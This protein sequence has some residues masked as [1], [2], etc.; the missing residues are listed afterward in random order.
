MD[1]DHI[2]PAFHF[3]ILFK[4][5]NNTGGDDS[6]FQSISGLK[7]STI[8]RA[9]IEL[10]G[11]TTKETTLFNP[12]VLKRA[13]RSTQRS[14]LREW[15]LRCLNHSSKEPLPEI[16]IEVLNEEHEPGL[17]IRL[18]DVT[19]AGWQLSELDALNSQLLTEEISLH[20]SSIDIKNYGQIEMGDVKRS[21]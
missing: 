1:R 15:V 4:G 5:L 19:A 10:A 3:R 11:E 13:V 6:G 14:P 2:M 16:L 17:A 7:I 8:T 9:A 20:Y 12:V 18:I 21:E